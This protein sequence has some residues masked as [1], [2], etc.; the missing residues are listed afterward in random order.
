MKRIHLIVKGN[1][2]GVFFRSNTKKIAS[3]LDLNGYVKNLPNGNV[4]IVAEGEKVNELIEFCKKGTEYAKVED[5]VVKIE[6]HKN[7]FESFE[8]RY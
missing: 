6:K 8:I 7:E 2:Q 5:I 1:V 4:E 3:E